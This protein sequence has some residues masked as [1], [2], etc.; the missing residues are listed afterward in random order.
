MFKYKRMGAN[1]VNALELLVNRDFD[2]K[3]VKIY[4]ALRL[5]E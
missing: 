2:K 1:A 4:K 5:M 3:I